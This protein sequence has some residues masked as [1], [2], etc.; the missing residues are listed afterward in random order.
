VY[1]FVTSWLYYGEELLPLAQPP[2]WGTNP[3]RLSLLLIQYIRSYPPYL[4]AVSSISRPGTRHAMVMW[5]R[6]TILKNR[7]ISLLWLHGSV[8]QTEKY[9]P[10]YLQSVRLVTNFMFLMSISRPKITQ[11]DWRNFCQHVLIF[12]VLDNFIV[13]N[14]TSLWL[15]IVWYFLVRYNVTSRINK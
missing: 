10:R 13:L 5:I 8:L 14:T 3:R 2:S 9:I 12:C 7:I 11:R 15:N 1:N 6:W 4:E